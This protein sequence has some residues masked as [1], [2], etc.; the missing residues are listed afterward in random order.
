MSRNVTIELQNP[1]GWIYATRRGLLKWHWEARLGG[2]G[3][4]AGS[5]LTKHGAM[6][7]AREALVAELGTDGLPKVWIRR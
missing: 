5:A 2:F 3:L 7:R 1:R 4:D 6:R